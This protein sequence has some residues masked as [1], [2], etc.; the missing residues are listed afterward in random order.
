MD[1]R[2]QSD[3]A[4][5]LSP[6]QGPCLS[7]CQPVHGSFPDTKQDV[8]RYRNLLGRLRENASER[9]PSSVLEPM[10]ARFD[11][12]IG[13]R[14]F[15]DHTFKGLAVYGAPDFFHV[16]R[17]AQPLPERA[18][19]ADTFYLKPLIEQF[20]FADRFQLLVLSRHSA[21]LYQGNVYG[22]EPV[23]LHPSVPKS[24][25]DVPA[26]APQSE[27]RAVAAKGGENRGDRYTAHHGGGSKH[28]VVN[29]DEERFFRVLARGIYE[30]HSQPTGLPLLLAATPEHQALFRRVS[31][32]P[33]L[34]DERIDAYPGDAKP[35]ELAAA[36]ARSLARRCESHFEARV[37]EYREA[38]AKR[39]ATDM[40][41]EALE[42]AHEGRVDALLVESDGR[43]DGRAEA[44]DRLGEP[45]GRNH[46][47]VDTLLD[48]VAQEVLRAGGE[49]IVLPAE[50]MPSRTGLAAIYRFRAPTQEA[51]APR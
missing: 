41:S 7:L 27:D 37:A 2:S 29:E 15:W 47:E 24:A 22:L 1:A 51:R 9:Y 31:S 11:A 4:T 3:I 16:V 42:A 23:A 39:L 18:V 49:V 6:R 8:L 43:A 36:A 44:D 17:T 45:S 48:D 40:A 34:L 35:T 28:D 26:T 33:H 12:L 32:N 20:Q 10:L 50:R 46:R 5:L 13:E 38:W 25:L 14:G 30:H 19:V 21:A